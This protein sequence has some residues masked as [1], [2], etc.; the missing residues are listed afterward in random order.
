[1]KAQLEL[2]GTLLVRHPGVSGTLAV[3]AGYFL[4]INALPLH[5]DSHDALLGLQ[6]AVPIIALDSLLML[7]DW[8]PG[9]TTKVHV[10]MRLWAGCSCWPRWAQAAASSRSLAAACLRRAAPAAAAAAAAP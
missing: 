4:H 6:C 10:S 7:P 8:S 3:A 2:L 9:T 1:L 5:W